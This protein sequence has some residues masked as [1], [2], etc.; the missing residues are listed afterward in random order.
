MSSLVES[1]RVVVCDVCEIEMR[2]GAALS[3]CFVCDYDVCPS[4]AG[5]SRSGSGAK[6]A[7]LSTADLQVVLE[8]PLEE[9]ETRLTE[10][11]AADLRKMC[12]LVGLPTGSGTKSDNQEKILQKIKR[13]RGDAS[14]PAPVSP[15]GRAGRG[16]SPKV[17]KA[18]ATVRVSAQSLDKDHKPKA[19]DDKE[20]E[21]TNKSKEDLRTLSAA[22]VQA[23]GLVPPKA[24]A[25]TGASSST[26]GPRSWPA[27]PSLPKFGVSQAFIGTPARAVQ[28]PI[29][30]TPLSEVRARAE[31]VRASLEASMP[32][33][34]SLAPELEGAERQ[35]AEAAVAGFEPSNRD[36]MDA[37]STLARN[38]VV[39]D[40]IRAEVT[41][42]ATRVFAFG[43]C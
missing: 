29:P 30:K 34:P 42:V 11:S 32:K 33:P 26:S 13:N 1:N 20:M 38:V 12:G 22:E 36:I 37:I 2:E 16:R 43:D 6:K 17:G 35:Q 3:S 39:R 31:A 4:C 7:S 18:A 24:G 21:A 5:T 14:S 15:E 19:G 8:L 27:P 28:V 10:L 23:K 25:P 40:D 9:L 41:E